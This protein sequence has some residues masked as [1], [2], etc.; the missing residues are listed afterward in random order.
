MTP[1]EYTKLAIRT[2]SPRE[3]IGNPVTNRILHASIGLSTE[4]GELLDQI[5][6]HLFYGKEL[7][8]QNIK[9]E[10]GDM[11]WYVAILCDAAEYSM[12]QAMKDNIAKLAKRYGDKFSD[13][14]ALNRDT[15]HEL[16]HIEG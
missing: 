9:E 6:K 11:L 10:I 13:Y 14:N 1:S 5:K 8:M 3:V 12:E 4:S 2:E 16:N 7:D 15:T